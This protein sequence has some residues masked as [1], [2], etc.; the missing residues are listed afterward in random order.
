MRITRHIILLRAHGILRPPWSFCPRFMFHQFVYI[1]I[2]FIITIIII[3]IIIMS[4]VVVVVVVSVLHK[5]ILQRI[6]SRVF[7]GF[8]MRVI[9][10]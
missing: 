10:R 1:I 8:P 6:L 9:S 3:I 4:I 7:H 2:I 5:S